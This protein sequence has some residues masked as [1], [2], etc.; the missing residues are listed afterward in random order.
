MFKPKWICC[1]QQ[2][3]QFIGNQS[4]IFDEASSIFYDEYNESLT[5]IETCYRC[6]ATYATYMIVEFTVPKIYFHIPISQE[7]YDKFNDMEVLIK[8]DLFNAKETNMVLIEREIGSQSIWEWENISEDMW[9]N[10]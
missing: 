9:D 2:S 8:E 6:K 10:I 5:G 4:N 1:L 7:N 3:K